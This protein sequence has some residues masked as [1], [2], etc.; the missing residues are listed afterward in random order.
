M[1]EEERKLSTKEWILCIGGIVVLT[2]LMIL[3][4]TFRILFDEDEMVT[5]QPSSTP[6]PSSEPT[7]APDVED[8]EPPIENY[9]K[10][11][12][13]RSGEG[14]SLYQESLEVTF[15]HDS[16]SLK[17]VSYQSTKMYDLANPAS[18]EAYQRTLST[19]SPVPLSYRHVLG[20][21]YECDASSTTIT[22]VQTY[23]LSSFTNTTI[24]NDEGGYEVLTT[25]YFLNQNVDVAR[26]GLENEGYYCHSVE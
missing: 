18:L 25:S 24:T 9:E 17:E 6:P 15:F 2:L 10:V 4:P 12:C 11:V 5:P 3:P 13:S 23:D 21:T 16:Q 19:C 14:A 7:D 26:L 22:T 20:F 1:E 8:P